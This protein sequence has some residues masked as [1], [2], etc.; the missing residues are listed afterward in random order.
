MNKD[1][2]TL[3]IVFY[4]LRMRFNRKTSISACE[5]KLAASCSTLVS[6]INTT[7]ENCER[8]VPSVAFLLSP[9][10]TGDKVERTLNIRATK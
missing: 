4:C 6:S 7:D 10:H 1:K 5:K 2:I 8:Q 3:I 9:V